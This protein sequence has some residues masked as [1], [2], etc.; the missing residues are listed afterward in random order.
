MEG[1]HRWL[2]RARVTG[3]VLCFAAAGGLSAWVLTQ[4]QG[5]SVARA[6]APPTDVRA[7]DSAIDKG[8]DPAKNPGEPEKRDKVDVETVPEGCGAEDLC[9]SAAHHVEGE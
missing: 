7:G 6:A 9:V 8:E 4:Q 5:P 3:A 2:E 1:L